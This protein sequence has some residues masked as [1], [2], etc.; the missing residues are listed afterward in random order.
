MKKFSTFNGF[1]THCPNISN[2]NSNNAQQSQT[3]NKCVDDENANYTQEETIPQNSNI[4]VENSQTQEFEPPLHYPQSDDYFSQLSPNQTK[5]D[6]ADTNNAF[7]SNVTPELT[8][9]AKSILQCMREHD[10]I[11]RNT[12]K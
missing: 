10:N 12:S 4:Q 11:I 9:H 7:D 1:F 8:I 5:K 6:N 3:D 2:I